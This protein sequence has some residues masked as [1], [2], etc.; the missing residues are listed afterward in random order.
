MHTY[1]C[2]HD[3]TQEHGRRPNNER[4]QTDSEARFSWMPAISHY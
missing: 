1:I 2:G 3:N 4:W